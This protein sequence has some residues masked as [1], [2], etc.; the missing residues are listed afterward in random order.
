MKKMF[1]LY[2]FWYFAVSIGVLTASFTFGHGLGDLFYLIALTLI[3]FVI[4]IIFFRCSIKVNM[5][6]LLITLTI[7]LFTLK[8]TIFRGPEFP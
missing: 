4:V 8:L 7:I 6:F 2:I 3:T 1:L 5:L